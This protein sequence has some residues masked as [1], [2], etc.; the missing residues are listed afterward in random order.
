MELSRAAPS[1]SRARQLR[2]R[3][4]WLAELG[5]FGRI[6]GAIESVAD[7]PDGH[8]LEGDNGC[9]LLAQPAD[10]HIDCLAI[11]VELVAPDV[12]EQDVPRV[13]AARERKQV[14]Q[15]V[16]LPRRQLDVVSVHDHPARSP[17]DA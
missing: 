16:E 1:G 9:E 5:T 4:P 8:D 11:A 2:R 12:L 7:A 13:H 10:V 15:E 17:V 6:T 14:R 3:P